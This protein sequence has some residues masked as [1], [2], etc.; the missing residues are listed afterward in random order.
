M[1]KGMEN[2]EIAPDASPSGAFAEALRAGMQRRGLSLRS[3][4]RRLR[5]RGHEVSVA[6]LSLWQ[7]GG[8]KPSAETAFDV[9][10]EIESLLDLH[11]DALTGTLTRNRRVA[12]DRNVPFADFVGLEHNEVTDESGA[13]QLSERSATIISHVDA[14]G[15]LVRNVIRNVWQA[16]VDGAREVAVFLTIE[17][18]EVSPPVVRGVLGC[19]LVDIVDDMEQRIIRPTLRLHAPLDRGDLVLTEWES[20]DHKYA[21]EAASFIQGL[22]AVRPEAEVGVFVYFDPAYL[23]RRCTATV[24]TDGGQR[25]FPVKV[26]ANSAS[27][28]E[29]DFGPGM[30]TIEWE[31]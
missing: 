6:T 26:V 27:H 7:S 28:V 12:Q 31:W 21:H 10:R 23:P 22:V 19:D 2:P 15:R 29:F 24:E 8:R 13:R 3:L 9:V 20:V 11:E 16:R 18:E 30:I 17:P 5:D 4:Q 14:D 25:V 1:A